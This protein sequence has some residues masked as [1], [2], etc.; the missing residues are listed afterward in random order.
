MFKKVNELKQIDFLEYGAV[1][2]WEEAKLSSTSKNHDYWDGVC[3]FHPDGTTVCSFLRIK[4]HSSETIDEMECHRNTEE[5]LVALS[6][7]IA[8]NVALAGD[9]KDTPD[10]ATIR[11]FHIKQGRGIL[12]KP[13][14]WH[15]L[16]CAVLP[17]DRSMT[18]VIFKKN[19]SYCEDKSIETDIHFA[20]LENPFKMKF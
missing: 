10:E 1:L 12:L 8:V 4:K 17:N 16:P 14:I 13:G 2:D 18:L 15:A 9:T 11:S 19:T 5:I 6:G 3:E 20:K 7:D